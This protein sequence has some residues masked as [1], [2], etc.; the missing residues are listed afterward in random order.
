MTRSN[1][2][3]IAIS[4]RDFQS[5]VVEAAQTLGWS[6]AHFR[7]SLGADGSHLTAVAYDGKGFPDCLFISP[8][9]RVLLV[10]EF[11]SMK[12]RM[13]PEQ[14]G[15]ANM[16]EAVESVTTPYVRYFVWRPNMMD[17]IV[18][19]LTNPIEKE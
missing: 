11:K 3:A 19:Y 8:G 15:W 16:F 10:V 2:T 9:H 7:T 5:S 13:S 6:V 12:G 18:E 1:R 4:E 14:E 17:Q